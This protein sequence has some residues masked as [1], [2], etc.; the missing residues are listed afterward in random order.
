M[1]KSKLRIR[2]NNDSNGVVCPSEYIINEEDI[3]WFKSI[4]DDELV[5]ESEEHFGSPQYHFTYLKSN[6]DS[7]TV[8]GR[9]RLR[10]IDKIGTLERNENGE[11]EYIGK[12][13][14]RDYRSET[15]KRISD[16][17]G[18]PYEEVKLDDVNSDMCLYNGHP[19]KIDTKMDEDN[20]LKT[21]YSVGKG[22]PFYERLLGRV[23]FMGGYY[24][25]GDFLVCRNNSDWY[26]AGLYDSEEEKQEDFDRLLEYLD[27]DVEGAEK[28]YNILNREKTKFKIPFS[29]EYKK[30]KD[31]VEYFSNEKDGLDKII[32]MAANGSK[33]AK[34]Y[35]EAHT[36][37]E[38]KDDLERL[39]KEKYYENEFSEEGLREKLSTNFEETL[40]GIYYDL[41]AYDRQ[42][43]FEI[44]PET[45]EDSSIDKEARTTVIKRISEDP[46]MISILLEEAKKRGID[47]SEIVKGKEFEYVGL[48]YSY[49]KYSEIKFINDKLPSLAMHTGEMETVKV[50]ENTTLHREKVDYTKQ[51]ER[52]TNELMNDE[53]VKLVYLS[54]TSNDLIGIGYYDTLVAVS[55]PDRNGVSRVLSEIPIPVLRELGVDV[56]GILKG[57]VYKGKFVGVADGIGYYDHIEPLNDADEVTNNIA[58]IRY[59]MHDLS[60]IPQVMMENGT[61]LDDINSVL[62]E[63]TREA[64]KKDKDET[65]KGQ[66]IDD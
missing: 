13:I 61:N 33:S 17:F 32:S 41:M 60:E 21:V 18:V 8:T 29:R 36:L 40:E 57:E 48:L 19:V 30:N 16:Y 53:N 39:I 9:K 6:I 26:L 49:P 15:R 45:G 7:V 25:I 55:N 59:S 64:K 66:G 42:D 4:P 54:R 12:D 1:D 62:G 24:K 14:N 50:D 11:F 2:W 3:D 38:E 27:Y 34:F 58:D 10:G 56:D 5:A 47:V 28:Y 35:L 31:I 44:D 51:N 20:K 37:V 65:K 22:N 46:K 63:F 23:K 43:F 52:F